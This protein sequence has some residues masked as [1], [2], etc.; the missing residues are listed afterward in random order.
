MNDK[1]WLKEV[2]NQKDCDTFCMRHYKL[3]IL[4]DYALIP[5][6]RRKH[7]AL[8]LDD[9]EKD[10]DAFTKLKEIETNIEDF[11]S[12]GDNLFLYSSIAGNGKSSWSLRMVESYF[13]KIW[14][15]SELKCKV[16]FISVPRFLLELKANISKESEYIKFIME[17]VLDCDLVIWD[18]IATKLGTEFEISNMLSIIDTRINK[19]LSNIYT[20]NLSE[21]DLLNALGE[22]LYS[23]IVN[24][25][26]YKIELVGKDKRDIKG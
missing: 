16:L 13:N 12:K 8:Y 10:L 22:R 24:Y 1:C 23:R 25:S 20:S 6:A 5:L 15:K 14:Y 4:Y 21:K 11:I 17:N 7:V 2:C 3:N 26:K 19:G 18:D 9:D